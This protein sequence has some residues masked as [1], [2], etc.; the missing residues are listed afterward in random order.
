MFRTGVPLD[1]AVIV[2]NRVVTIANVITLIRLLGLPLFVYLSAIRHAWVVSFVFVGV[3][4]VLDT[5]DGYVARRFNQATKLGAALDPL[6]DRLTVVTVGVTL[7]VIG[8]IPLWLVALILLR[9]GLLLI[10]AAMLAGL[11]RP[12]PAGRIPVN[13]A[14]KMATM[15]LLVGLPFLMLA[16]AGLPGRPE[17]HAA[18]LLLTGLGALLYYVALGQYAKTGL[19]RQ[20]GVSSRTD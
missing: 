20:P 14:G 8:V 3:L 12:V 10:L 6:T 11:G 7:F 15:A 1:Q 9:D 19:S 16:R 5:L 2:T 17:I 4:A 13:R 18:G